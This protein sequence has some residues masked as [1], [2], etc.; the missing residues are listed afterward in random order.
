V[1]TSL[2]W[3]VP[4]PLSEAEQELRSQMDNYEQQQRQLT[5]DWALIKAA[6][7]AA[8]NKLG[9]GGGG[10]PGGARGP[11]A[12][13]VGGWACRALA[14]CCGWGLMRR[15]H[16]CAAGPWPRRHP[17]DR[18]ASARGPPRPAL[19][20]TAA[21]APCSSPPQPLSLPAGQLDKV[22][23]A[24]KEQSGMIAA[25]LQRLQAMHADLAAH[26]RR[27]AED[28][29]QAVVAGGGKGGPATPTSPL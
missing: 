14:C 15:V 23:A 20:T 28:A 11:G 17:A 24:L 4:R 10:K 16:S 7:K 29:V 21:R 8:V 18:A 25:A 22:H 5:A 13:G 9:G 1:L 6:V 2:H 3:S 26:Q 27:Q 19:C 12:G